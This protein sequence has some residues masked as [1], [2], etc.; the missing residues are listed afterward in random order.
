V[1]RPQGAAKD[2]AAF[3]G[4]LDAALSRAG[5]DHPIYEPLLERK[6]GALEAT[7]AAPTSA[8]GLDTT[9]AALFPTWPKLSAA[10]GFEALAKSLRTAETL[11]AGGADGA[12]TDCAGP[13][14]LWMKCLE[15]YMHAWLGT[16][17]AALQ[18][19]PAA[20]WE[21]VDRASTS[22]PAYQRWLGERWSDPVRVGALSV[23]VP[24][25]SAPN[26][27]RELEGRRLKAI[28]SPISVNEWGRLL[29]FFGMDHAPCAKN[30]LSLPARSA[31]KTARLAHRLQVLAQVR[32]AV[33]HRSLAGAE[34]LVE[35]RKAYYASFEE[36]TGL[37]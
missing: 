29:L 11:Y 33:T 1:A 6:V 5:P 3:L 27:L 25:R 16:R 23:E 28:D 26:A 18:R 20:L 36:L 4:A 8:R 15:G 7:R 37:A 12:E 24:L 13:I 9:I 22:W 19:Q 10:R 35:F 17:F 31:D 32:N 14:V 21:L 2:D 30:V 34:T